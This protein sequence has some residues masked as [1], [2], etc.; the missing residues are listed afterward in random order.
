MS[1]QVHAYARVSTND[2]NLDMQYDALSKEGYDI[3]HEE[4]TSGK[5]KDNRPALQK[6][7]AQLRDGDTVLIY[8]LDRISRS[9]KDLLELA[10]HFKKN[11]I[12]FASIHDKIDTN[13]ALGNF[14][15][16][17]SS[18]ISQLERDQISARTKHGLAAARRKGNLGGRPKGMTKAL[19]MKCNFIYQEYRKGETPV[20]KIC[21][22]HGVSKASFYRYKAL[23]LDKQPEKQ[24][25]VFD[26]RD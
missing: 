1:S 21:K 16:T 25:D 26:A 15:F 7:L 18:A 2:Q 13:T 8:K 17:V 6:M 22:D 19:Q 23:Y 14:F 10:E 11:N 12:H 24:I 5:S 9:T 3:L 4:K 20:N